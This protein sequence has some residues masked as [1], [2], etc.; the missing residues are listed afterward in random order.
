MLGVMLV[1]G[2]WMYPEAGCSKRGGSSKQP[3]DGC[4]DGLP[5]GCPLVKAPYPVPLARREPGR[6]LLTGAARIKMR[7]PYK[8]EGE[9]LSFTLGVTAC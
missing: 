8:E 4:P 3:S 5:R 7:L 1:W 9:G 6:A 2:K